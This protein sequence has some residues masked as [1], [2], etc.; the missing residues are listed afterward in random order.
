MA[1]STGLLCQ[2]SVSYWVLVERELNPGS[3]TEVA[4]LATEKGVRTIRHVGKDA[5]KELLGPGLS[6][7]D[8]HI[9]SLRQASVLKSCCRFVADFL[10]KSSRSSSFGLKYYLGKACFLNLNY[11]DLSPYFWKV[12]LALLHLHFFAYE[13]GWCLLLFCVPDWGPNKR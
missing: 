1:Q 10:I 3:L 5:V 7:L 4:L 13:L 6:G 12:I 9:A 8:L 2:R 11:T